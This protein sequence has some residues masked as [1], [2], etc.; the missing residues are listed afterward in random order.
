MREGIRT[1]GCPVQVKQL[2]R[3]LLGHG[4][5]GRLMHELIEHVFR[6]HLLPAGIESLNDSALFDVNGAS[7]AVTTDS[8]VV[9]PIFFPGGDIGKLAVHGTVNDL[10]VCG[11][12]PV[13]MSAA[14]I[15]EEGFPVEDLSRVVVSMKHACEEAGVAI[16]TGDTKVVNRG[17]CDRIF[18]NTTGVGVV[19]SPVK[20][21]AG[22]ARPGDKIIINGDIAAHGIAVMLAREDIGFEK[23]VQSDTAPL[24]SLVSDMLEES[25]H[26]HCMRDLTRGGLSSALNEIAD[27]SHVGIRIYEGFIP[28]QDEVRGACEIL[29]LDP[30]QVANEGKL[31]AIVSAGDSAR[32]LERMRKNPLGRQATIIG[33]VVEDHPGMV[34]MK[35]RVGGFRVVDMLTGEQLPR[36]C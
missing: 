36:I 26:I 19:N 35:T 30:L 14:F 31:V 34:I 16:V 5:G 29:G 18:I 23:P 3:I 28:I 17:K 6:P 1:M 25:S 27:S 11:A 9:D 32:I 12:R 22:L 33:E 20:I 13:I 8:F 7:L 10:A 15:L 24:N 21:S 4:S 2:E